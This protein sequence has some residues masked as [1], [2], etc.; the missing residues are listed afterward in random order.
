MARAGT[1]VD[2]GQSA[3]NQRLAVHAGAPAARGMITAYSSACSEASGGNGATARW[4]RGP[5]AGKQDQTNGEQDAVP[6]DPRGAAT[7]G[8]HAKRRGRAGLRPR[9]APRPGSIR[10]DRL[11][12]HDVL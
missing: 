2:L 1:R 4:S 10:V 8:E 6:V 7:G 9:A 12:Q 5:A 3:R 11:S